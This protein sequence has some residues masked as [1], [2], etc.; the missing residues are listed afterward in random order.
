M[1]LTLFFINSA[2]KINAGYYLKRATKRQKRFLRGKE[3]AVDAL[4]VYS[5]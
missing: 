4:F 1:Q 5:S 3:D 2:Q